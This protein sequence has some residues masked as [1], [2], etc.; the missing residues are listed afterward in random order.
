MFKHKFNLTPFKSLKPDTIGSNTKMLLLRHSVNVLHW[1]A[2]STRGAGVA[3][4]KHLGLSSGEVCQIGQCKNT[5]GFTGHYLRLNAPEAASFTITIS[6]EKVSPW[7]GA[8]PE[9][10][11]TPPRK[12]AGGMDLE[13]EAQD[14]GEPAPPPRKYKASK[15]RPRSPPLD[16]YAFQYRYCKFR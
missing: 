10:S 3:M 15:K 11:R 7:S 8:Q 14:E 16:I 12:E 1:G 4:Y 2:H 5:T 13:G 9:R 6:R